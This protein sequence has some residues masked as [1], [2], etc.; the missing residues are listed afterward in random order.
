[1]AAHFHRLNVRII[2]RTQECVIVLAGKVKATIFDGVGKVIAWIV[3][4]P[5]D[6]L[7]TFRGGHGY[8]VLEDCR[9]IETKTGPFFGKRE[10]KQL[11]PGETDD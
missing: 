6:L 5:G 11:I 10:D 9:A 2:N 1:M 3:L 4:E 8:E 7:V